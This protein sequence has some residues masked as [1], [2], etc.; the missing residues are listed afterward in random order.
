M[1]K[2]E[3][4]KEAFHQV[5]WLHRRVMEKRL[6]STGVF[7]SQHRILMSLAR[8]DGCSQKEI[9][10]L[11][12]ISTAAMTVHLKKLEKAGLVKREAD[13]ADHR[14]NVICLTEKGRAVVE[15]SRTIFDQVD[16]G[17]F[18]G[19]SEQELETFVSCLGQMA[20]NLKEELLPEKAAETVGGELPRKG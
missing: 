20:Q 6:E 10:Q 14:C 3:I 13:G 4:A 18:Y 16:S 12:R 9:A 8:H 17:M 5:H 2:R 11:H 19:L 1:Q 15:Q 7:H